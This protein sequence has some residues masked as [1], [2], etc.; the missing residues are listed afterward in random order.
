VELHAVVTDG[1]NRTFCARAY[2]D[3]SAQG[4]GFGSDFVYAVGWRS[5]GDNSELFVSYVIVAG[6][7]T[8]F[9]AFGED[10]ISY[11][12]STSV[13]GPAL[14]LGPFPPNYRMNGMIVG[15]H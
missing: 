13:G 8:V 10:G 11:S 2:G 14:T 12:L 6:N 4:F 7:G 3:D 9:T 5:F 15:T 1:T